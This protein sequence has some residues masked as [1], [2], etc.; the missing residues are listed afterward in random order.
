[1]IF[2][3]AAIGHRPEQTRLFEGRI[4]LLDASIISFRHTGDQRGFLHGN[5]LQ[6]SRELPTEPVPGE[7]TVA[8]RKTMYPGVD[9]ID[10]VSY[11]GAP[12]QQP[13]EQSRIKGR[14]RD[15]EEI[16]VFLY[17]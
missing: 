6:K 9:I 4:A 15:I 8:P 13:A 5:G 12:V 16:D 14:D 17:D 11:P 2:C 3:L 7:D 1:M 10:A